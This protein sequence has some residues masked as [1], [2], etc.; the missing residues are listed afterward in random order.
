MLELPSPWP[1]NALQA[2]QLAPQVR[3]VLAAFGRS[4]VGCSL[5]AVQPDRFYSRPG[6]ARVLYFRRP[7]GLFA[8]FERLEFCRADGSHG[9]YEAVVRCTG[10]VET[11]ASYGDAA[12]E[13]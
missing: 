5:L 13:G 3:E 12:R 10:R 4:G 11:L 6:E 7:E 2:P 9:V 8:D 1:R